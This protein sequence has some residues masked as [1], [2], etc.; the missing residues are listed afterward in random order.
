MYSAFATVSVAVAMAA[1]QMRREADAF[2][3]RV[4]V[5]RADVAS[6]G[7]RGPEPIRAYV[8]RRDIRVVFPRDTAPEWSLSAEGTKPAPLE[9]GWDVYLDGIDGVRVLQLNVWSKGGG[10]RFASFAELVAA[11]HPGFCRAETVMF[12]P[13][14][15]SGARAAVVGGRLVLAA[16]DSSEIARIFGLR[17]AEVRFVGYGRVRVKQSAVPI[18]YVAPQIPVPNAEFRA[19]AAR[20]NRLYRARVDRP[21]RSI[22]A[23]ERD[24]SF[25]GDY[26]PIRLTVG[27]SAALGVR[28]DRC[29][30]DYC[31]RLGELGEFDAL[32]RWSI[33]DSAVA[34]VG[35][36]VL[37]VRLPATPLETLPWVG[38][39][40]RIIDRDVIVSK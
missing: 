33:D 34:V 11:G 27:D 6:L 29:P 3:D 9:Y 25:T 26:Q 35:R 32:A 20:E 40:P 22:Q 28:E 10:W 2:G 17:P 8:S 38:D 1:C 30:S 23:F 36:A 19:R 13:L 21:S 15:P 14:C 18:V 7:R 37:R 5:L 16:Q 12:R 4:A 24:F 31:R 39:P